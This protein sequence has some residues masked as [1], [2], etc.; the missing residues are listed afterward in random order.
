MQPDPDVAADHNVYRSDQRYVS[1]PRPNCVV[2]FSFIHGG[3][4]ND[5]STGDSR[6]VDSLDPDPRRYD[7]NHKAIHKIIHAGDS[8]H[9][10]NNTNNTNSTNNTNNILN[11]IDFLVNHNCGHMPAAHGTSVWSP[12]LQRA[13]R[14]RRRC[15]H[16]R[17]AVGTG[18]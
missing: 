17:K 15:C 8:R 16:V 1:L 14:L 5:G 18:R 10:C 13:A 9:H 6:T 4:L 2:G 11:N 3:E 12:E 7:G